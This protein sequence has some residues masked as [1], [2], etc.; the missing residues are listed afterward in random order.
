M[1][2]FDDVARENIKE[3]YPNWPQ[4][5]DHPYKI[6]VAG[7]KKTNALFNLIIHQPNI[8]EA[9]LYAKDPY[10]AKYKLLSN[11]GERVGL[12]HC[13]DSIF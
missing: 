5:P 4:I 10:K 2:R 13:N 3:R 7:S 11:K 6:L 1:I 12:K 9:Y 8:D